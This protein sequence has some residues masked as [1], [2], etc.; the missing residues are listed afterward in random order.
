M[1]LEIALSIWL[2]KLSYDENSWENLK[3]NVQVFSAPLNYYYITLD[4]TGDRELVD[5]NEFSTLK[6]KGWAS[7]NKI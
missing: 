3:K 2:K 7:K 5:S 6:A 4:I 1:T